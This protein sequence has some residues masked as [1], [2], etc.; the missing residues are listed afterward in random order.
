MKIEQIQLTKI[1]T[2][3][4]I[5]DTDIAAKINELCD[6]VNQLTEQLNGED[7]SNIGNK[8]KCGSCEELTER[9]PNCKDEEPAVPI[10]N[11]VCPVC[12]NTRQI[13]WQKVGKIDWPDMKYK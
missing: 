12:E 4:R 5:L 10:V 3:Y 11:G 13:T 6:R 8:K 9:C 2:E 1:A 7:S